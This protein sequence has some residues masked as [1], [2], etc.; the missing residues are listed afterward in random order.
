MSKWKPLNDEESALA[1]RAFTG[2][3][4][5]VYGVAEAIDDMLRTLANLGVITRP[6]GKAP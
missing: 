6:G 5:G 4:P 1:V 3:M 2:A